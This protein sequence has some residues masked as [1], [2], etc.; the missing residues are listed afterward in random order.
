MSLPPETIEERLP[1]IVSDPD[2]STWSLGNG[3]SPHADARNPILD[4]AWE[5]YPW[6]IEP[7]DEQTS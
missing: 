3:L 2:R 1:A 7:G 4:A 5:S 6:L